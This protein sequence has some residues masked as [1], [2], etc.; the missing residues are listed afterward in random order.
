MAKIYESP[1]KGASVYERE[2]G[3]TQRTLITATRSAIIREEI[4]YVV[5]LYENDQLLESRAV[6]GHSRHYAEDVLHNWISG[7][8]TKC[9]E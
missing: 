7:L 9:E 4:H 8:I 3:S 1:D 2:I 6:I 5:D